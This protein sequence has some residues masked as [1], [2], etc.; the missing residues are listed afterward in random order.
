VI[1]IQRE[2]SGAK[3]RSD[4]TKKDHCR[5]TMVRGNRSDKAKDRH[6]SAD[7]HTDAFQHEA[8]DREPDY[9]DPKRRCYATGNDANG[10]TPDGEHSFQALFSKNL[11]RR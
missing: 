3:K 4:E 11:M 1:Y 6:E 2:R 10:T 9:R 7:D 5:M 8:T